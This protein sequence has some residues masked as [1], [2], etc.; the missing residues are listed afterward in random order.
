MS[1]HPSIV[2]VMSVLE[3]RFSLLVVSQSTVRDASWSMNCWRMCFVEVT[4]LL[5]SVK[6]TEISTGL[7]HH[8]L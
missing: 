3:G 1:I 2:V 5:V 8:R 7:A 6:S 4:A